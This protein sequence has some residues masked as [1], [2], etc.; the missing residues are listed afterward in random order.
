LDSITVHTPQQWIAALTM[1]LP[2]HALALWMTLMM[3]AT[4]VVLRKRPE[5]NVKQ[6]PDRS[7]VV[8]PIEGACCRNGAVVNAGNAIAAATGL[9]DPVRLSA[10]RDVAGGA[11]VPG[12]PIW[13][14]ASRLPWP[15][16]RRREQQDE[17]V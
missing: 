7:C 9:A 4:M 1:R 17:A 3:A 6:S 8:P 2:G 10:V 5:T 14:K 11:P 15:G 16:H 13:S 12:A